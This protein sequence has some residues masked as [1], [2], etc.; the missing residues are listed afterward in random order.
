MKFKRNLLAIAMAT[1]IASSALADGINLGFTDSGLTGWT[2]SPSTGAQSPTQWNSQGK[3]ANIV[4]AMTN[5]TPGGGNTWSINPYSGNYMAALQPT[6]STMYNTMA[7]NFGLSV[8]DKA[9][10]QSFLV[11]KAA[12]GQTT[13]TNAS[14][15]YY[16]G[17]NLTAGT[18]FTLAWNFVATDYTPWNDTSLTSLVATTGGATPKI[19][20]YVQNYS[21]LGAI[22]TGAG[23]WSVG[24]YGSSG[25]QVA[26]YEVLADGTYTLGIG[27]FNLGD[28]ALSPILLVS[29]QQ[30]TTLKNGQAFGAITSNDPTIQA[31]VEAVVTPTPTPDPTPPA[32]TGPVAVNNAE[33]TTTTNPVGTTTLEV[34]NA[35]TYTNNGTNS[36]V[37]NTGTFTNNATTGAVTN[38]SGTFTNASTGTTGNVTNAGTFTN[39]GT[40]GTVNNAGTFNN[41]GTTTTVTNTGTFTNSGTTGAFTNNSTGLFTNTG[42][43]GAITN[44]GGLTVSSGTTGDI[45][46]S[47]AAVVNGGVTGNISNTGV[48]AIGGGTT[49]SVTNSSTFAMSGGAAGDVVNTGTFTY[50]GG[51]VVGVNNSGTYNLTGAG[52]TVTVGNYTQAPTGTTVL[53]IA[54]GSIQKIEVTGTANLGGAVAFNSA[55]G[56][57]QYGKYTFL[58]AGTLNGN[59]SLVGFSPDNIS[60]LG[61]GIV[62]GANDVAVE[63]TPSSAYTMNGITQTAGSLSSMNTL[64]MSNLGGGLNYD[65][66]MFGEN[67]MCISAGSRFTTDGAGKIQ[68]GSLTVG[69]KINNHWRVGA[70]A[71]KSF[72]DLVVGGVKDSANPLVGA[73][74]NWNE[75]GDGEGLSISVAAATASSN[76]NVNRDGSLYSESAQGKTSTNGNAYQV[77]ASY[78]QPLTNRTNI[79]PYVGVRQ[80]NFT[81]NGYTETGATYPVSYNG[82]S[83]AKTD[84]LAGV[85]VSHDFDDKWSGFVSAGVIKNLVYKQGTLSGTSNI[86]GLQTFST[87]LTGA[88]STTP[89]IGAG[90]SYDVTPSQVLGLS[91][92]Y[93][94]QSGIKSGALTYTVGF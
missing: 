9:S 29:G 59:Y 63:I 35:G 47:G 48:L 4:S 16:S 44:S 81:T 76:L 70:F 87:P 20:G 86:I 57:Y 46:N 65:C 6:G 84:L 28:T 18:K 43:T 68:S 80:T 15:M 1:V 83:Q 7:S 11:A 89:V 71:D 73:F 69:K 58:T 49:G 34:T 62:Q 23:N 93:Q 21:V 52:S 26:S 92:G 40:T 13:P 60:P 64:K 82:I 51:T 42:T 77:K 88:G 14:Y 8:S 54:P 3:G 2:L 27:D 85:N 31:A 66:S 50:T 36:D 78:T 75:D 55:A 67:G 91:V 37:T 17:L 30:G 41:S 10:I 33:G 90:V 39:A 61:F 32:P 38:T 53:N 12:G 5:Y 72:G 94:Q 25:W 24:S 22:N 56:P 19:N 45:T 79:S 74:A